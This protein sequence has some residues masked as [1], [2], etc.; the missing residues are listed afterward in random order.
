LEDPRVMPIPHALS[1]AAAAMMLGA[2]TA[3]GQSTP[4]SLRVADV[5]PAGHFVAESLTKPW[6]QAVTE[7]TRGA[8]TFQYYPGEQ[9]GKGKD[10]LQLTLSGVTDVGLV[11]PA[12]VS[13]KLPL[14]AVAEL[15]GG[16]DSSCEG[17]LAYWS[18]ARN[19][20]LHDAEFARNNV[21]ILLAVVLPGYQIFA[22]TPLSNLKS[23]EGLKIYSTGGAK[24]LTVRKIGAVPVRMSTTEV[25]ESLSRGTID[26]ALMSYSTALAY[27]LPG[28]VKFGTTG[29][30]FGSGVITYVISEAKWK[31]LP[32]T[33]QSAMSEA[34]DAA[35][36]AACAR[37]DQGVATDVGKLEAAGV[38]LARPSDS[39]ALRELTATVNRDWAAELD[40]RGRPGS[41]VL[42]AFN[43]ALGK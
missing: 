29:E 28:L 8:V 13:D 5:Y 41:Q 21:R 7:R 6:M 2:T 32:A 27:K 17:T 35:T 23:F 25:F 18:L 3:Q 36:R 30:N 4:M 9:L 40:K 24:D 22:R 38:A 34:G 37:I 1:F 42:A 19:G 16:F 26:G 11:I 31:Q 33:V 43:R 12:F 39:K 15:P 10:L 14:S 20:I